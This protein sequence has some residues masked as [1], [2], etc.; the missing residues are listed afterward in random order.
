MLP[1][2]EFRHSQPQHIDFESIIL[3]CGSYPV[4]LKMSSSNPG[5][6]SLD[7]RPPPAF[8]QLQQSKLPPDIARCPLEGKNDPQLDITEFN[9]GILLQKFDSAHLLSLLK[10]KLKHEKALF[11]RNDL[12]SKFFSQNNSHLLTLLESTMNSLLSLKYMVSLH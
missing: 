1:G 2:L 8:F 7:A 4:H 5:L 3:G 9:Q 10:T 6:C 11:N 12:Y